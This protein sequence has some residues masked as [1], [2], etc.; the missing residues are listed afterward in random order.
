M[1]KIAPLAAAVILVIG[2]TAAMAA[3]DTQTR[4]LAASCSN[5]HGTNGQAKDGMESLAGKGRDEMLKKLLDF[6]TGK[7]PASIMHQLSKG[8]TDEELT[9]IVDFYAAMKK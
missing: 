5:C 2:S 1:P 4:S 3:D 8:Y 6:K 9:R 7:K